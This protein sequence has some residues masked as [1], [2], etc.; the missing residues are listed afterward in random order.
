MLQGLELEL[1]RLLQTYKNDNERVEN[2]RAY[3]A[4]VKSQI[5]ELRGQAF[6]GAAAERVE[7]IQFLM[8]EYRKQIKQNKL[9]AGSLDGVVAK[10]KA[11]I[12]LTVASCQAR[13]RGHIPARPSP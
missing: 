7:Y 10:L 8:D 11:D 3:I 6:D 4:K 2:Q 13:A 1:T 12:Q 9:E 5:E